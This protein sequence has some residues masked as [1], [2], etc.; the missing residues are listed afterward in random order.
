MLPSLPSAL[1]FSRRI[2][3]LFFGDLAD[4]RFL[5]AG[6][7]L[8][9]DR[10]RSSLAGRVENVERVDEKE[11]L[12]LYLEPIFILFCL[13]WTIALSIMTG[14]YIFLTLRIRND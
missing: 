5:H 9:K 1:S 6:G 8:G 11:T 7:V 13:A 10:E 3:L 14:H 4:S 12:L 2:F